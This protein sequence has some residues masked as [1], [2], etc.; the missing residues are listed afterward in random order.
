MIPSHDH[1][2]AFNTTLTESDGKSTFAW[3]SLDNSAQARATDLHLGSCCQAGAVNAHARAA[4]TAQPKNQ[5]NVS[6]AA[7]PEKRGL[8]SCLPSEHGF[9]SQEEQSQTHVKQTC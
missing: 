5:H 1:V 4:G 3:S 2:I 6:L 7:C 8:G 9:L